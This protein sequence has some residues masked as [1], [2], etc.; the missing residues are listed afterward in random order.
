M[1]RHLRAIVGAPV[2]SNAGKDATEVAFVDSVVRWARRQKVDRRTLVGLGVD[3]SVLDAAGLSQ[4]S[5]ASSVKRYFTRKPF[6]VEVVSRQS[7]VS[8]QVVRRAFEVHEREGVIER[9]GRDG[10]RI[11][12]RRVAQ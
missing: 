5:R 2:K 3:R 12:Y 7:G 1:R 10:Q 11:L 6:S 8:I 9:V 4:E